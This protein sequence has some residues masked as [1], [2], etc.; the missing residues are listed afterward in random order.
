MRA[1]LPQHGS[2]RTLPI[3]VRISA[4]INRDLE[5]MAAAEEPGISRRTL[6]NY[7]KAYGLDI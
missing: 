7:I 3:G 5:G 2:T 6:L 1:L 4:A